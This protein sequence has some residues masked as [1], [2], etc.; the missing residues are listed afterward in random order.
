MGDQFGPTRSVV[1]TDLAGAC[2][3]EEV[4]PSNN[5]VASSRRRKAVMWWCRSTAVAASSAVQA[6]PSTT[7]RVVADFFSIFVTI[8][9]PI[10]EVLATWVP[11]QGW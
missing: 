4:A 5:M 6:K 2:A 9:V 7:R 11:P 3:W 1:T 10:S 8:T